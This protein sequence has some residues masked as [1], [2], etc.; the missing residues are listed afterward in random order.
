[1]NP[2]LASVYNAC[3]VFVQNAILTGYSAILDR[4]RYGGRFGEYAALMEKS[5]WYRRAEI[6]AYQEE[7]LKEVIRHA[8]DTVPY[9][10]RLF[11]DRGLKPSDV[12]TKADL[13]K[14]PLLTKDDIRKNFKE[15]L[16]SRFALGKLKYGHTSG[17][18]GSPSRSDMTYQSFTLPT[19]RWTDNTGGQAV[20]WNT[21]KAV[22]GLPLHGETLL[23]S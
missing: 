19:R 20:G 18:T 7:R 14:L 4:E 2:Y 6:A 21:V 17:T 9:Y 23:S 13:V 8:Y 3:P 16:S 5:Q 11:D 12:K 10:R 15:L 22:I 1:M